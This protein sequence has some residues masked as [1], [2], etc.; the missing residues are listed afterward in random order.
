[1]IEEA[2]DRH[3]RVRVHLERSKESHRSG[4]EAGEDHEEDEEDRYQEDGRAYVRRDGE[5]ATLIA[6]LIERH[7]R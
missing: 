1:V 6:L 3:C 5:A 4:Q 7:V 2:Q